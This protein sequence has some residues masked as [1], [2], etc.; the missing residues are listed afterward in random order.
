M[1]KPQPRNLR[2]YKI[3]N[4]AKWIGG[5]FDKGYELASRR[6][7]RECF[8]SRIR[9]P[10]GNVFLLEIRNFLGRIELLYSKCA[11]A[12]V[13]LGPYYQT[14]P[15]QC[16]ALNTQTAQNTDYI[17]Q[18]KANFPWATSTDYQMFAETRKSVERIMKLDWRF[19]YTQEQAQILRSDSSSAPRCHCH[20]N[21]S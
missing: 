20:C 14:L 9:Y 17:R 18:L 10:L 2:S 12:G 13:A 7:S 21:K 19:S 11:W 16:L 15:C 8:L 1:C 5:I 3:G 4:L 6:I